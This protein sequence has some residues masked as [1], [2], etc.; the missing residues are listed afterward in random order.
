MTFASTR[1]LY[2]VS[3]DQRTFTLDLTYDLGRYMNSIG[4]NEIPNV[5]TYLYAEAG[6]KARSV[7]REAI[8]ACRSMTVVTARPASI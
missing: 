2:S 1:W 8:S 5:G 6:R 7:E 4:K 3:I